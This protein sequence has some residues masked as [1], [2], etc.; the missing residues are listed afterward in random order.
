M[1]HVTF[2]PPQG[3]RSHV[4]LLKPEKFK[5]LKHICSKKRVWK[6]SFVPEEIKKKIKNE[7]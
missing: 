2:L 6:Y 3:S 1:A 5:T 7:R 4:T